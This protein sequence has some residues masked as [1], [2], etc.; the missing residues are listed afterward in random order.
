[1]QSVPF[2]SDTDSILRLF[3]SS[4]D[5]I[6]CLP[7]VPRRKSTKKLIGSIYDEIQLSCETIRELKHKNGVASHTT[8]TRPIVVL[9]TFLS[10]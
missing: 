7:S 9:L 8:E 2:S 10:L 5:I 1:M 3:S 4:D 6:D